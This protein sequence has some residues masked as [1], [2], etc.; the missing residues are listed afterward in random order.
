MRPSTRL[1]LLL[2]LG[3]F[4][5]QA[6]SPFSIT[7]LGETDTLEFDP[8]FCPGPDGGF[9]VAAP[10]DGSF[11]GPMRS[12]LYRADDTGAFLLDHRTDGFAESQ[13]LAVDYEGS[14]G[15]YYAAGVGDPTGALPGLG[16]VSKTDTSLGRVW[17]RTYEDAPIGELANIGAFTL[18]AAT[19]EFDR[20]RIYWI[21]KATGDTIRSR[22]YTGGTQF[23]AGALAGR[24]D[25]GL[26]LFTSRI[27]GPGAAQAMCA[28]RIGYGG[29][30]LWRRCFSREDLT[31]LADGVATADGGFFLAG[32]CVAGADQGIHVARTDSSGNV[33]YDRLYFYGDDYHIPLAATEMADGGFTLLT[34]M[35]SFA[36]ARH[37]VRLDPAG[38]TLWT[39][40]WHDEN[41]F[42]TDL[43]NTGTGLALT[44][45]IEECIIDPASGMCW[46]N[47]AVFLALTDYDGTNPS[48]VGDCVWPGDADFDGDADM[49]DLLP[50]GLAFGRTGPAR[51]G[52]TLDWTAQWAP[53][54]ADTSSAGADL[55]HVDTDG[56]ALVDADDTLALALNYGLLHPLR[57]NGRDEGE[58]PL[59]LAF[60]EDSALAGD[61]VHLTV[62]LGVDTSLAVDILGLALEIVHDP[63]LVDTVLGM[64]F[65][66]SWLTGSTGDR[67][68][69]ARRAGEGRVDLGQVRTN[70]V[71]A[72]GQGPVATVRY[73]LDDDLGGR[74]LD[75][76]LTNFW[77]ADARVVAADGRRVGYTV[78]DTDLTIGFA[79]T[80]LDGPS[81][82]PAP[83]A[84][85]PNPA[86]G[87]ARV[88]LPS[89]ARL[90]LLDARGRS[91]RAWSLP[92]GTHALDL[93]GLAPG[94]YALEA[95]DADARRVA[96]LVLRP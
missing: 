25:E 75:W 74:G 30:T 86:R 9:L 15:A 61:T 17:V 69:M 90:R 41:G 72:T 47:P 63:G 44:G 20:T 76:V 21:D 78:Y 94:L 55:K 54:W 50:I 4:A 11:F 96:R 14:G 33:L 39:R 80:G 18:V 82:E 49:F 45:D 19:R 73:V 68:T 51:P 93:G 38:D 24:A 91:R 12:M 52:A 37:L 31:E 16:W 65:N 58:L 71:A 87:T 34:A 6:Q 42:P 66:G 46:Y 23:E 22:A 26:A 40:I 67:L 28:T 83:L 1:L 43:L 35:G 85:W 8:V 84:V 5:G 7:L 36:G 48:C 56:S 88:T 95:V 81:A 79:A 57:P 59:W 10:N 13:V 77:V 89:A 2:L 64:S 60:E 32:A 27:A 53:E 70:G 29:D 62:H 3:A 92:A